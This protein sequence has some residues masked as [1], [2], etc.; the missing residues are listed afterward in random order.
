MKHLLYSFLIALLLGG[1]SDAE[2]ENVLPDKPV[3]AVISLDDAQYTHLMGLGEF[4]EIT[5][6]RGV[7][8][9]IG[10]GGLLIVHTMLPMDESKPFSVYDL[11]C[12]Y[13]YYNKP[14][15]PIITRV[16][17]QNGGM[18][19]VCEE[20]N[21]KYDISSGFGGCIEGPG[22]RLQVYRAAYSPSTR[23]LALNN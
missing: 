14:A 12:P 2:P 15:S 4:V 1:C 22:K 16:H 10:V 21:S 17:G 8:T 11:A 18:H 23:T 7:F 20:C 5:H 3:R 19:A 13:C 9:A 6:P